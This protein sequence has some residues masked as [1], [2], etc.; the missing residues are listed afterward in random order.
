MGYDL[1]NYQ[2]YYEDFFFVPT[3][4]FSTE[5][6]SIVSTRIC[7]TRV[8]N[9]IV[10]ATIHALLMVIPRGYANIS[11]ELSNVFA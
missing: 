4:S 3:D 1:G 6:L 5:T 10:D 9:L 11:V 2:C 8:S 7:T